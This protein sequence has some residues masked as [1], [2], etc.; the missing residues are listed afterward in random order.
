MNAEER[1]ATMESEMRAMMRAFGI[2]P[3]ATDQIITLAKH[4]VWA[5]IAPQIDERAPTFAEHEREIAGIVA[6]R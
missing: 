4:H 2:R 5:V 3:G 6:W 1:L